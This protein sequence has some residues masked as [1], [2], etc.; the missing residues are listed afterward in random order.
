MSAYPDQSVVQV[1][2]V[3]QNWSLKYRVPLAE[4][5]GSVREIMRIDYSLVQVALDSICQDIEARHEH[6]S[7][8]ILNPLTFLPW[9]LGPREDG[10]WERYFELLRKAGAP[11]LEMFETEA[12]RITALLSNPA[13][14]SQKRKGLVMGNVQS[15]KT[16]NF[17]GVIAQAADAGYRFVIVLAGMH[18]NLRAQTQARLNADLFNTPEWYPLTDD[19][20]DFEGVLKPN[21]LFAG[22]KLLCAVVKKNSTRLRYLVDMMGQISPEVR[23]RTPVLI[24]DDEADQATP[25]SLAEKDKISTINQR[26]RDLWGSVETGTYLAYTATPFANVLSDPDDPADLFPSDFI[27]TIE[28][29]EGYFG[30]ERV[31][32]VA[33]TTTDGPL[34]DG[35]NMVRKISAAEAATLKPPSDA[36]EREAFDPELP[37]S[38][39]AAVQWFVVATAIRRA[40]GQRESHSSMLVHTTHYTAPHF[41]MK[42]RLAEYCDDL[43]LNLEGST[44]RQLELSWLQEA[45]KVSS[46]ATLPLPTWDET[47]AEIQGVLSGLTFVVDNGESQDRLNYDLDGPI[48]TVIAVGGGTLSRGLTLEGLI[49]S[50]FT[51]TSNTYDTLLQMGRWFGY[52]PGYEDLPRVW[53]TTGLDK[54]Y[55]HLARVEKDLRDDIAAVED[56]EFTPEQVGIRIRAHPGRLEITS[57]NKMYSAEIVQLG[58]SGTSNQTFL[59]DGSPQ[60]IQANLEL[61]ADL[62]HGLDFTGL[63]DG[64]S[65]LIARGA[66]GKRISTFLSHFRV[67]SDQTWLDNPNRRE[68]MVEWVNEMSPGN[69]W[70]IVL[71]GNSAAAKR[72]TAE[73]LTIGDHELACLQR[74]PMRHSTLSSIDLKALTSAQDRLA[75]IDTSAYDS[76][77]A[78]TEAGRRR[79]RRLHGNGEGLLLLYP[80]GSRASAASN[81]PER[82][83][84]PTNSPMVGFAIVFPVVNDSRRDEGTFVSVRRDWDV[85]TVVEGDESA[86]AE[87]GAG[88]T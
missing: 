49:V 51:R 35:L 73:T 20:R 79:V 80:L 85:P 56:S 1:K 68:A 48:Q 28:P 17:A 29:G 18:N 52:R 4:A 44:K 10:Q 39:R 19:E 83:D 27:T 77:L 34:A 59:L 45:A 41:A 60:A 82:M 61:S 32:G 50:Y 87:E 14:A 36:T 3:I 57:R 38:L 65:R 84:M 24:V 42:L 58:L 74:T 62:V 78:S 43:L 8:T 5:A 71:V 53:V 21:T 7:S 22:Q 6:L 67:S 69:T 33:D 54:D 64:S 47:W 25:N 63:K 86:D 75:D 88:S 76:I 12:T 23:R 55:A 2:E 26:L 81:S 70:N 37:G 30:A 40:R 15:G 31:F 11:G 16:R 66:S 46:E 13:L 72:G 9:H